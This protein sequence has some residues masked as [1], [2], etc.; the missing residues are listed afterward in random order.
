MSSI[1]AHPNLSEIAQNARRAYVRQVT[2]PAAAGWWTA[3]IVTASSAGQARRYETE[4]QRRKDAGTL[5]AETLYLVVPD[6]DDERIG[7]GGATLNALRALARRFPPR[8]GEELETWWNRQRTLV[9]HSGGDSRRLPEYSLSGKLFSA[10]P[11]KTPWGEVSTVFDETLALSTGW[12]QQM[13]GGLLVSSGDVILTFPPQQLDWRR[14]GVCGVAM[15]QP[16]E[17]GSQHG[18]YVLGDDGRVYSFL[19]KPSLAEVRAA[20]GLLPD[21]KVALDAGLIRFDPKSAALL[22][23][24]AGVQSGPRGVVLGD[25]VLGSGPGDRP[26]IDLYEDIT[27]ALTGEAGPAGGDERLRIVRDSF[28]G[29]PFW[30][31]LVD[32]DFTHV[33]TT[34]HFLRLMTGESSFREL[35]TAQQRLGSV[36]PPGVSSAGVVVDSVFAAGAELGSGSIAIECYLKQRARAGRGSILH[37]LIDIPDPVEAPDETV[38]HQAPVRP[39]GGPR[40]VV[41]RVY[42]VGDDPKSE[43][44]SGGATWFGRPMMAI[45]DEFGM[46]PEMV[47]GGIPVGER[48]LW[49]ARLFPIGSP[50][51][52]WRAARWLMG[53][54]AA[55]SFS[56]WQSSDRLSLAE[57]ALWADTEALADARAR[58]LQANWRLTAVALAESGTD[59]RP[60]LARSPG[61]AALAEAGETLQAQGISLENES[62]T[63]AASR[64]F[65]AS[66]FFGQAGLETEAG[67]AHGTAFRC[68]RN[69]VDSGCQDRESIQLSGW[70]QSVVEVSAPARIDFGGGWSDTPPFCLDWGGAVFNMA[71]TLN[72]RRPIRATVRRLDEPLIRCIAGA[73]EKPAEIRTMEELLVDLGPGSPLAVPLAALR[74]FG[75][76]EGAEVL[77]SRLESLGGGIEVETDV[78]LPMGSGL[79]TSSILASAILRALAGF[80]GVEMSNLELSDYVMRLE[81]MLTTGGGWQDQA[82]GI[83]PDAKLVSTGPGLR[84]RLR[85]Q[86]L[87][88]TESR[89]REFQGRFV[90]YYTG[91]RRVAKDLLSQVVGGYLAREAS[92]LQVLH[93][94]KTLAVEMSFAMKEGEWEY[95]G[96]LLDRHWEHNQILDPHTTNAPIDAILDTIRPHL[97]GVKLA[98]AGGGGF[99]M[100]LAKDPGHARKLRATLGSASNGLPGLLYE[101]ET[102]KE[103]LVVRCDS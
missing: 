43:A 72:G 20:G 52:S 76:G 93:S 64:H 68:V 66:L 31:S 87:A 90:L 48:R 37:G 46:D 65:Q 33:G 95:L 45:L 102:A 25:G 101:Y 13:E 59:V 50:E 96:S 84:Q 19:Q 17:I 63:E 74:L 22:A 16:V 62:P 53:L 71:V 100:L 86:P 83:F 81:Q 61:I 41:I 91:I 5:P 54:D 38:V 12:A 44:S 24:L 35:Y 92:T 94:I 34:S 98:G 73:G 67:A 80:S 103:G 8:P 4:I 85:V 23:R 60:L 70:R 57:S 55:F 79:G 14:P 89:R 47:W 69:A 1:P 28:G 18:V 26:F 32:G 29:T 42:G 30:C 39:E 97:S 49:N 2:N 82:G 75:I 51:W 40:G 88:W 77:A 99:L 56:E 78:D 3:V 11:V 15:R 10:L 21:S 7:S 36:S 58:R 27:F 9:I 6:L